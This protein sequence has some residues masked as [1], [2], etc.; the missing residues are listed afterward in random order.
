MSGFAM[1]AP[2]PS[3]GRRVPRRGAM[4]WIL[5]GVMGVLVA[6]YLALELLHADT[7]FIDGWGVD[8]FELVGTGAC[9][10]RVFVKRSGRTVALVLGCSLLCWTAGDIALTIESLG[11]AT[12]STPSLAD[13]FYLG[14]FPFAYVAVSLFMR[15]GVKRLT[16]S[17]WLD[18]AV[19]GLG[20]ASI[21]AAFAFPSLRGLAGGSSLEVATDLAYPVGDLLLLALVVGGSALLSGR[22]LAPWMLL[23]AGVAL[24]VAGDTANLLSSSVGGTHAGTIVN[25]TAW[26]VSILLMSMAVW[27][28]PRQTNLDTLQKP[29]GLVLPGTAA[30][31][32]LVIL[33]VGTV[34]HTSR[35]A[36]ALATA[37]LVVAGVRL[38]LSARSLRVLTARH[39]RQSMTDDLTRLGNRR[40]LF[41]TLDGFFARVAGAVSPDERLAF[42]F[43]D[44]N[45]FKELNDAF[46]HTAG[47]EVLRLL[48]VRLKSALRTTDHLFRLGGDEFAVL[49]VGADAEYALKIAQQLTVSLEDPFVLE[50]VSAHL[51][52]SIGIAHAPGDAGDSA[53]LMWSADVAMYRAKNDQVPFAVFG[54]QE[55]DGRGNYLRLA[56]E[57][58]TGIETDQLVLHYQPLLDLRTGEIA[59][60]EALVRWAHPRFG[61]LPPLKFLPVAEEA[62]LMAELTRWV[63]DAA[64]A[65]CAAWRACDRDISVA[66]NISATNLVDVSFIDLISALL[67]RYELPAEALVLEITETNII[68]DFDRAKSVVAKLRDLGFVVSIDDFGAGVTSLASLGSLAVG[69]LKLDRTFITRLA[70]GESER[71]MPLIHATIDL[72]HSLGMRVVAEGVEDEATLAMLAGF[73]CDFVQG[74]VIDK[75]KPAHELTFGSSHRPTPDVPGHLH[76][77]ERVIAA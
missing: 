65:Q 34:H 30:L 71:E 7:D 8:A 69:E 15:A 73:G 33:A 31:A 41:Q 63:L 21:L 50:A 57:L 59:A 9:F 66:V 40:H 67:V 38:A 23:A 45:D 5:Y 17:S 61:L 44:L 68:K 60:V 72:G 28:R 16:A 3:I 48:G 25:A 55:V 47:D 24:N 11:G 42:L 70:A 26:P 54:E 43:V 46:G 32:G 18:G 53:G 76:A 19:A 36:L 1:Q 77:L 22:R 49:L 29:T 6:T 20:A 27:L 64:L 52:A 14:Y 39:Y 37:T 56:D 58:R 13:V 12:P 2:Q 74:Y 62:G 51:S 75:P 4:I 35:V 10:A